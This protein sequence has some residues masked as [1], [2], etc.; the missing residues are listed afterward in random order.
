MHQRMDFSDR[1]FRARRP[2]LCGVVSRSIDITAHSSTNRCR[3]SWCI[4]ANQRRYSDVLNTLHP[5]CIAQISAAAVPARHPALIARRLCVGARLCRCGRAPDTHTVP[6]PRR[7]RS[8]LCERRRVT[9]SVYLAIAKSEQ[10][11]HARCKG[12]AIGLPDIDCCCETGPFDRT[13]LQVTSKVICPNP[14]LGCLQLL[15]LARW[16]SCF[17]SNAQDNTIVLSQHLSHGIK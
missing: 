3:C 13:S 8:W 4:S 12:D 5:R 16:W 9:T 14:C 15:Y 1:N 2:T 11:R 7:Q 6:H 10:A 17:A